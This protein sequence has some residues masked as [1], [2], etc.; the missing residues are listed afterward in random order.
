MTYDS[1]SMLSLPARQPDQP[2]SQH[3]GD[4][5]R[6]IRK[7]PRKVRQVFLLSRLDQLSY[8]E[9]ARL[10]D[11]EVDAIELCMV[12]LLDQCSD[13]GP[14]P[15]ASSLAAREARRWYVH[16]QS[17]QA[18]PSQRIEFRHWLDA[19]VTHVNAFEDAERLWRRLKAPATVLGATG[20]YR[21]K[22]RVVI[23]WLVLTALL[24]SLLMSAEAFS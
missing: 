4:D 21:R 10:L 2:V 13:H 15:K 16:L 3:V 24:C 17:P 5:C 1:T 19:D 14:L 23:G 20:W 7:L 22:R 9:I 6:Q 8:G 18:T 11:V 12:R